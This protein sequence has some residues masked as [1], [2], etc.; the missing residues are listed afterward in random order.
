[1]THP[2]IKI[3][4]CYVVHIKNAKHTQIE[5]SELVISSDEWT[6]IMEEAE[7]LEAQLQKS[8]NGHIQ[9]VMEVVSKEV[10]AITTLDSKLKVGLRKRVQYIRTSWRGCCCI[11][12]YWQNDSMS[13]NVDQEPC[14]AHDKYLRACV[15]STIH[16]LSYA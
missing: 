10:R 16:A 13:V 4:I 14:F 1:M 12:E 15:Q 11:C 8:A 9:K 2:N 6:H 7:D 3:R 5:K